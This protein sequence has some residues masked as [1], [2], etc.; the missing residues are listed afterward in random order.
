MNLTQPAQVRPDLP[1]HERAG[2]FCPHKRVLVSP[3]SHEAA[4][5]FQMG[6]QNSQT[7]SARKKIEDEAYGIGL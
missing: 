3:H 2:L 4:F 7:Y 5:Q 1:K 6:E